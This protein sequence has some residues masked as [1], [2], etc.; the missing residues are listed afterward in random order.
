VGYLGGGGFATDGVYVAMD[1]G[2]GSV[3]EFKAS[4]GA[5]AATPTTS[6]LNQVAP[7]PVMANG[8]VAW[9]GSGINVYTAPEGSSVGTVKASF[10]SGYTPTY[11][12]LNPQGNIAY[13][14]GQSQTAAYAVYLFA[15]SLNGTSCYELSPNY[16][17][18]PGAAGYQTQYLQVSSNYAFWAYALP[19]STWTVA[20]YNFGTGIE[21]SVNTPGSATLLTLDSAAVYWIAP[22]G[23]SVYRAAQNNL[24]SPAAITSVG[25]YVYGLASDGTN[26]YIGTT[27]PAANMPG[28]LYYTPVGGGTPKVLY[29]STFTVSSHIGPIHTAGG[30][31]YFGDVDDS[32]CPPNPYLRAIAAP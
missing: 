13:V 14:L 25:Q 4:G 26:V 15:C 22:P 3:N 11:L 8:I 16:I 10:P 9:L 2:L 7:G 23:Y 19:P 21:T 20:T 6:L 28:V 17:E 27:G 5:V 24:T 31:V 1:N 30:A 18:Y 12:A 32:T 29:T